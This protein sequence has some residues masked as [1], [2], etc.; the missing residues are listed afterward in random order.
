MRGGRSSSGR[1]LLAE[2]P[3]LYQRSKDIVKIYIDI[4][5]NKKYSYDS[6]R[7]KYLI[8]F[9]IFLFIQVVTIFHILFVQWLFE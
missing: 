3:Q 2:G 8:S 7:L 9:I 6:E 1:L 5:M 4:A